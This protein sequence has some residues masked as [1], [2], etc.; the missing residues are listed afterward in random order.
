REFFCKYMFV[1]G[2]KGVG[3]GRFGVDEREVEPAAHRQRLCVNRGAADDEHF[4]GVQRPA[5]CDSFLKRE[6][7]ARHDDVLPPRQRPTYAFGSLA[8]HDD[9]VPHGEAFKAL[10]V[11]GYGPQELI[12]ATELAIAAYSRHHAHPRVVHVAS[13][14]PWGTLWLR[15]AIKAGIFG[16][17]TN[18]K[19]RY[20]PNHKKLAELVKHWKKLGLRIVLTSGTWDL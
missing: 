16:D 14:A 8:P 7:L 13:V 19:E 12:G 4:F 9:G 2:E 11:L 10:E 3:V 18:H 20:I 1:C 17:G 5:L 15:M 6:P